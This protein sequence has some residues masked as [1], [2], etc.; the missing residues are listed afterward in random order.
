VKQRY[1]LTRGHVLWFT[2]LPAAG[3]TTLAQLL[4]RHLD[5]LEINSIA[6]DGDDLRAVFSDI[7]GNDL[8]A[9]GKRSLAY[10][11]LTSGLVRNPVVVLAASITATNAQRDAGRSL[12]DPTQFSLVWVKTPRETC[13]ARDP[14]GLYRWAFDTVAQGQQAQVVGVDM[15]FEDPVDAELTFETLVESS[16]ACCK[17]TVEYLLQ[18]GV[19]RVDHGTSHRE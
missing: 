13:I 18:I 12:H 17:K 15:A 19:L 1:S 11:R 5:G 9:R 16:E 2:G 10:A 7:V 14:K 6:L 3:K 8:E 4:K